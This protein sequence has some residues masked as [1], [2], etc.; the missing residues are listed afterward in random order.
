MTSDG[1]VICGAAAA[2]A[3]STSLSAEAKSPTVPPNLDLPEGT[4]WRIDV[5][6][7]GQPVMSG[8]FRYGEVP[9]G[10]TQKL[11]QSGSPP[12][13]QSGQR[14]YIYVS[15]DV[16]QPLTRCVFTAQ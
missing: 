1:R 3:T 9:A 11:P 13:L 8:T 5:P 2:R 6:F 14:Y 16:I 12:A 15:A 4:L 10:L 7:D